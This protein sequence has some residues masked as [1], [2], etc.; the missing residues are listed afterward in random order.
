M[1]LPSLPDAQHL[2]LEDL[3]PEL[4][5]RKVTA[6]RRKANK[7]KRRKNAKSVHRVGGGE[8]GL[9]LSA[10]HAWTD[11]VGLSINY[12]HGD[13]PSHQEK[14]VVYQR[15]LTVCRGR[16]KREKWLEHTTDER[17]DPAAAA[18]ER[19]EQEARRREWAERVARE[20]F[21]ASA[22]EQGRVLT[23]AERKEQE[24]EVGWENERGWMWKGRPSS[25]RKDLPLPI[26]AGGDPGGANRVF[27]AVRDTHLMDT[28][29]RPTPLGPRAVRQGE[30]ECEFPTVVAAAGLTHGL[31][32]TLCEVQIAVPKCQ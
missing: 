31:G 2:Q 32:T 30:L 19:A 9:G 1:G 24:K 12:R 27:F 17:V 21:A 10:H 26:V 8:V 25:L 29:P 23:D 18:A 16:F 13:P 15:W 4:Q 11:G 14:G 7:L 3:L 5:P 22:R 28:E 6:Q 20:A